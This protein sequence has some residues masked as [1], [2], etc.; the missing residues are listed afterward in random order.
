MTMDKRYT[1]N[2]ILFSVG[3]LLL[4]GL[5]L[6]APEQSKQ[7]I[8]IIL[9]VVAI[10]SG[11]GRI[12]WHFFKDN[13]S[14][15]FHN[16]IPYGVVL[17]LAGIYFIAR[18]E[19]VWAWLPVIM[20]FAVV[21]DSFIKLQNAFDL[22]RAGLGFWW[23]VLVAALATATLGILLI[24]GIFAQK[25]LLYYFGTVLIVDGILNLATLAL[26]AW[27][28]RKAKNEASGDTTIPPKNS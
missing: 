23:V 5:L 21:F 22:R 11:V 9:G 8:C 16:D 15:A 18:T 12:V 3:Y 2:F 1:M 6:F 7:F 19:S 10:V 17:L 26:M 27:Q 20:G 14:R 24:L 25:A 28:S 13:L 4:G